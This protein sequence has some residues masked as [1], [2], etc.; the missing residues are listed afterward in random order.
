MAG[1][2]GDLISEI[3]K[4]VVAAHAGQAIDLTATSEELACRYSHLGVPADSMA[5][6]IARSL[7]AVGVS[8]ALMKP[9]QPAGRGDELDE[10]P[11]P[12]DDDPEAAEDRAK[13]AAA[14]F[15]S[16]VRL[17]VLS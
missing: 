7:S 16:G 13:A 9:G 5:R 4:L 8:M 10:A 2:H 11:S 15:P 14:L 3:G 17:A 1:T 6:A 12:G